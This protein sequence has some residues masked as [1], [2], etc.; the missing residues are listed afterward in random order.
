VPGPPP[1]V[2]PKWHVRPLPASYGER[3]SDVS[4]QTKTQDDCVFSDQA[5]LAVSTVRHTLV[6]YWYGMSRRFGPTWVS[7]PRM[8]QA[9]G[10]P[11][12]SPSL[13]GGWTSRTTSRS[14]ISKRR[15]TNA[16]TALRWIGQWR[17]ALER[18]GEHRTRGNVEGVLLRVLESANGKVNPGFVIR[19]EV[20]DDR[21][22][23]RDRDSR[24]DELGYTC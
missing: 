17:S 8:G 7:R 15:W 4:S 9:L 14:Q 22:Q 20:V 3:V 13:L 1:A 21:N 16:R 5:L 10:M 19:E 24:L 6:T 2:P 18:S 23:I 11:P 12:T